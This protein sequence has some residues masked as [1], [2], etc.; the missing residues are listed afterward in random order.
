MSSGYEWATEA[1]TDWVMGD[2]VV[3]AAAADV[4]RIHAGERAEFWLAAFLWNALNGAG[5]PF[6]DRGGLHKRLCSDLGA[7][8]L[9]N[10]EQVDFGEIRLKLSVWTAGGMKDV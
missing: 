4:I 3:R 2:P 8:S 9:P 6:M 10:F 1:V 7:V 5:L